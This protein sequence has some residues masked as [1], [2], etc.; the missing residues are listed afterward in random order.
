VSLEAAIL[1]TTLSP[2]QYWE[3]YPNIINVDGNVSSG[4]SAVTVVSVNAPGY[5]TSAYIDSGYQDLLITIDGV[6]HKFAN[7]SGGGV[8]FGIV[9]QSQV[10]L[11]SSSGTLRQPGTI[12][13]Y[14]LPNTIKTFV[15][16]GSTSYG[17]SA[18]ILSQPIQFKSSLLIQ[19][20][21]DGSSGTPSVPIIVSGGHA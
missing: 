11:S 4:A 3:K 9:S 6:L 20:V 12:T 18:V 8:P 13:Y 19:V 1:A 16:G 21:N 15:L 5:L 2:P 17:V 10:S 14:N 7:G